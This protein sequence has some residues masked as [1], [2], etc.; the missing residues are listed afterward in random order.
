MRQV[1]VQM[2]LAGLPEVVTPDHSAPA[3]NKI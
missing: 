2:E 3:G 1:H